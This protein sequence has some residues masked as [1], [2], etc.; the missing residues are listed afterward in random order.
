MFLGLWIIPDSLIQICAQVSNSSQ[1]CG[2]GYW[3]VTGKGI[4]LSSNHFADGVRPTGI[5]A[6][7]RFVASGRFL[8]ALLVAQTHAAY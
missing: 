8:T 1:L 7:H 5:H 2:G 6:H 3:L 4:A